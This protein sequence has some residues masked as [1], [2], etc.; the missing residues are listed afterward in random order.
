[1]YTNLNQGRNIFDAIRK[2]IKFQLTVNL[3]AM[4]I[5]IFGGFVIKESPINA[6]QMLWIN[7][8]MDSFASL[9]LATEPPTDE[10]LLRPPTKKREHFITQTMWNAICFQGVC[11]FSLLVI[12]LF[13]SPRW[14]GVPS[15]IDMEEFSYSQAVH[16]TYFFNVFVYLQVFNFINARVLKKE[17]LNPFQNICSNPIF[18]VV[19]A[20]TAVG[21]IAFVELIGRPV[22]CSPLPFHMHLSSIALGSLALPFALLEKLIPDKYLPFPLIFKE[23]DEVTAENVTKGI[24]SSTKMGPYG[25]NRSGIMS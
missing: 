14:L 12:V 13:F 2:F 25:A 1:M 15:S 11:Q 10:L 7:V 4:A 22:K 18:W 6:I 21:Q 3:V 9:A 20:V 19:V 17:E 24:M 16:F 23:R 8:I 5:A